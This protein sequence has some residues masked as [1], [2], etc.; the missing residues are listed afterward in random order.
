MSAVTQGTVYLYGVSITIAS[1]AI[2]SLSRKDA[3][4]NEDYVLNEDGQR[5]HGRWDDTNGE[6]TVEFMYSTGYVVPTAGS[7]ISIDGTTHFIKSVDRNEEAK[8]FRKISLTAIKPQY[9]T[10]S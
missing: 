8:G 9:I 4:E 2:Q 1:C 7:T 6:K 5:I 10:V 3:F